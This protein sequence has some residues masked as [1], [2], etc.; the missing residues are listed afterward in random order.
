MQAAPL[1]GRHALASRPNFS[2][3]AVQSRTNVQKRPLWRR[4]SRHQWQRSICAGA[5]CHGA[6]LAAPAAVSHARAA[7]AGSPAAAAGC[8]AP[9]RAAQSPP[10]PA[11]PPG[12][13]AAL[14]APPLLAAQGSLGLQPR[15]S[16][17]ESA[18][19]IRAKTRALLW[20]HT[21]RETETTTH[22]ATRRLEWWHRAGQGWRH[23]QRRPRPALQETQTWG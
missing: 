5:C 19:K 13:L 23:A 9:C 6:H 7:C 4:H 16:T 10:A 18:T 17:R 15:S 1:H 2:S 12:R 22:L 11:Q 21:P 20:L 3:P 14:A 8:R